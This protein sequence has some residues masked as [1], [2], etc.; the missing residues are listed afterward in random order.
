MALFNNM[1]VLVEKESVNNTY[2][3]T[4][5][6]VEKGLPLTD[7]VERKAIDFSVDAIL[8]DDDKGNT[9][10]NQYTK[11]RA[12]A[13]SG[14]IIK[15]VGRNVLNVAITSINKS[16]DYK[17]SNGA[18]VSISMKEIRMGKNSYTQTKTSKQVT[19][20]ST[21]KTSTSKSSSSSSKSSTTTKTSN[22]TT[23]TVRKGET[24]WYISKKYGTTVANIKS[25][26]KLKS[27]LIKVGQKLVVRK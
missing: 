18:S 25:L 21:S 1:Y 9:A 7:H 8:L 5:N 27:D 22:Y 10:Y 24:L 2:D 16:N 3:I 17:I 12:W 26:N 23:H 6:K 13:N 4:E 15:F 11:L 14:T 19:N 20:K